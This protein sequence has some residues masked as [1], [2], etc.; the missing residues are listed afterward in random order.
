MDKSLEWLKLNN[1]EAAEI[2]IDI[3]A[4]EKSVEA[5]AS[6]L[7]G[8]KNKKHIKNGIFESIKNEKQICTSKLIIQNPFEFPRQQRPTTE[9]ET[10]H[11]CS[12]ISISQKTNNES[13]LKNVTPKVNIGTRLFAKMKDKN[14]Y[15]LGEIRSIKRYP[16]S[17]LYYVHFIGYN[18][19]YDE[20][21]N[22][23]S[24]DLKRIIKQSSSGESFDQDTLNELEDEKDRR[25]IESICL[26]GLKIYEKD[27]L[28]FF[29]IDGTH[30]DVYAM[31]LCLLSKLF[32]DHKE[33]Y[34]D[35]KIFYFYILC[36]KSEEGTYNIVGYFSKDK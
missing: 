18:R 25:N 3:A 21:L 15:A 16:P 5:V 30:E 6:D 11:D 26:N 35:A 17:Y 7:F 12:Q 8:G 2:I 10:A 32:L 19:R 14:D 28:A 24:L 9:S 36:E 34:Y 1:N 29:E 20:W 33:L 31:N 22:E 13:M 23:E 27:N 4:Y